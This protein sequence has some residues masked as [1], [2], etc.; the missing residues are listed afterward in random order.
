MLL[1]SKSKLLDGEL[2]EKHLTT[3]TLMF[4]VFEANS[5]SACKQKI[6]VQNANFETGQELQGLSSQHLN[7]ISI[8][9]SSLKVQHVEH[10]MVDL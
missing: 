10:S 2:G 9:M 1:N 5:L 3:F 4:T 8:F 6:H 7:T